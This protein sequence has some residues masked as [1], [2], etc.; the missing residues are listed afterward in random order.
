MQTWLKLDEFGKLVNKD[1]KELELLCEQNKLVSKIENGERLIEAASAT[2]I[3]LPQQAAQMDHAMAEST[4]N[5]TVFIEKTIGTIL[6]LHEKV[7]DA[8]D[9]TLEALRNENKFLKDGLLAMQE[10]YEEDRK[11]IEALTTQLRMCQEEL[12][13]V[14]RKYKLMWGRAIENENRKK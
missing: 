5:A 13:F 8:K 12:E 2:Q 10:L 11:A 7:L 4:A 14:K 6:N 1:P 9:E 3:L